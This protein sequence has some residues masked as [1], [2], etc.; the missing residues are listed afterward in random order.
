MVGVT[1]EYR[2]KPSGKRLIV[3]TACGLCGEPLRERQG[4]ADHL[5][6]CPVQ[7]LYAER[8]ALRD[9]GP[10]PDRI[11][12]AITRHSDNDGLPVATD[13]GPEVDR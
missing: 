9:G 2:E 12:A 8:G 3:T 11:Q 1:I 7:N 6:S 5:P 10:D 4:M 13:G